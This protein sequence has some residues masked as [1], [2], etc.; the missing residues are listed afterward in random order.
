[1]RIS[2]ATFESLAS[3]PDQQNFADAFTD[4]LTTEVSQLKDSFVIGRDSASPY[5]DRPVDA[6]EIGGGLGVRYLLEGSASRV[7]GAIRVSV[8]LISTETGAQVWADRF[9]GEAAQIDQMQKDFVAR[10]AHLLGAEVIKT[11]SPPTV[12]K[13]PVAPPAIDRDELANRRALAPQ[14]P[15]LAASPP[16]PQARP[17][18]PQPAFCGSPTACWRIGSTYQPV[19]L[20]YAP[21]PQQQLQAASP[22]QPQAKPPEPQSAYCGSPLACWRNGGVYRPLSSD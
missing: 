5:K 20:G 2:L 18:E 10:L 21:A 19:V 4:D 14:R 9:E 22:P 1:L 11:E 3:D 15:R 13:Q 7:A 6:R 8:Q 17:P 12:R 16:P